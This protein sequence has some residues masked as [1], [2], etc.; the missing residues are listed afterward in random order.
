ME[1]LAAALPLL[2][3]ALMMPAMIWMM[4]RGM[5]SGESSG[6]AHEATGQPGGEELTK[7][8]EEVAQL[9]SELEAEHRSATPADR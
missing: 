4:S 6:R 1:S 2:G 3:C 7:L 5:R 8:R 9:R